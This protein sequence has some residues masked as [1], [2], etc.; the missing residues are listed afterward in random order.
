MKYLGV[1]YGKRKIGLAISDGQIASPL[2]V[3]EVNSLADAINKLT[4]VIE[5]EDIKRVVI[6]VP[7]GDTGV[8]V[9]KFCREFE[10][11]LQDKQVEIIETDEILSSQDARKMMID[12]NLSKKDRKEED[13][14]SAMLILQ[15]F[16]NTLS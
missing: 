4:A 11:T 12:L 1:D 14:Y 2:K 3:I 6:G 8:M 15:R 5:K 10:R 9:R 7:E 13:A 16:L